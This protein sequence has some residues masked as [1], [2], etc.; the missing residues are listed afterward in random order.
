MCNTLTSLEDV[1]MCRV[2]ASV[3]IPYWYIYFLWG[4]HLNSV[5][6]E[7]SA[8]EGALQEEIP[9]EVMKYSNKNKEK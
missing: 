2:R 1:W 9:Q 7:H 4:R 5:C 6:K 8:G 3:S